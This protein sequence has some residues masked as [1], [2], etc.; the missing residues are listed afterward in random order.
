LPIPY[1]AE[2]QN[3]VFVPALVAALV[4]TVL[5]TTPVVLAPILARIRSRR[6]LTG[7]AIVLGLVA[8]VVA[9]FEAGAGF[10]T[11]DTQHADLQRAIA[12]RYGLQLR[13]DQVSTLIEG[14]T[15]QLSAQGVPGKVK[16]TPAGGDDYV[17]SATDGT[18]LPAA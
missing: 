14:G 13:D 6:A 10:R 4:A 12:D 2:H 11:L 18:R 8:L 7:V 1:F 9:V 5:L 15:L 16:L 17:L 3:D